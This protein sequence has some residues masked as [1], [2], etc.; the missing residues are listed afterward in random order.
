MIFHALRCEGVLPYTAI[1]RPITLD[2]FAPRIEPGTGLPPGNQAARLAASAFCLQDQCLSATT[3]PPVSQVVPVV[4]LNFE[5]KTMGYS[6]G[7]PFLLS[8]YFLF[9]RCP[10]RAPITFLI[11]RVIK[12]NR[13]VATTIIAITPSANN[14]VKPFPSS[15]LNRR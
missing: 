3:A 9:S 5:V 10:K 1:S 6:A 7:E 14:G 4:S 13:N 2:Q 8:C 15:L 11:A 12:K